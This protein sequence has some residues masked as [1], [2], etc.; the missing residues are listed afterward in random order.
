MCKNYLKNPFKQVT[1]ICINNKYQPLPRQICPYSLLRPL[2]LGSTAK[3]T[4]FPI[5]FCLRNS[6]LSQAYGSSCVSGALWSLGYLLIH[7]C[8]LQT[9]FI[10][11]YMQVHE[12]TQSPQSR[13][14]RSFGANLM[15][16]KS[17]DNKWIQLQVQLQAS[18]IIY[19][20][21]RW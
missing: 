2:L 21:C 1:I 17:N 13:P 19:T 20:S 11:N 18:T 8:N 6:L 7:W 16:M 5:T 10:S 4:S 9:Y 15:C 3:T 12:I 14:K